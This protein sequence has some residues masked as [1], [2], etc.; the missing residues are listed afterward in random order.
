MDDAIARGVGS[1]IYHRQ[2]GK[3]IARFELPLKTLQSGH[4]LLTFAATSER[5]G[6]VTREVR[7][8]VRP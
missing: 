2:T 1:A 4:Y 7:F 3:A 6:T 5:G 8:S